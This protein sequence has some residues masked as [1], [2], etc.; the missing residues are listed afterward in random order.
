MIT[1]SIQMTSILEQLQIQHDNYF[2]SLALDY[3]SASID[4]PTADQGLGNFCFEKHLSLIRANTTRIAEV[5]FQK[6]AN[7]EHDLEQSV[8][9]S[10]VISELKI[11][12]PFMCPTMPSCSR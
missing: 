8:L 11:T 3:L 4:V 9:N 7:K 2:T 6:K 1:Y 10:F 5:V 12:F